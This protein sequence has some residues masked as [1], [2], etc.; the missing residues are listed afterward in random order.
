M[1]HSGST[2]SRTAFGMYDFGSAAR[3]NTT[4]AAFCMKK[5]AQRRTPSNGTA[6]PR[7][8]QCSHEPGNSEPPVWVNAV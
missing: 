1:A 7:Y 5:L 2:P 3:K 6:G 8:G 4:L